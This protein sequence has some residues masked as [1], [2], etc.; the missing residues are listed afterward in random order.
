MKYRRVLK[1]S[2]SPGEITHHHSSETTLVPK[3]HHRAMLEVVW[4]NK[5]NHNWLWLQLASGTFS[6]PRM[7]L[8]LLSSCFLHSHMFQPC[9]SCPCRLKLQHI[10]LSIS[11]GGIQSVLQGWSL[12][13]P[14]D[15]IVHVLRQP[16]LKGQSAYVLNLLLSGSMKPWPTCILR[17]KKLNQS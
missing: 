11:V 10:T 8:V 14:I 3:L 16:K 13:L 1:S 15:F 17:K 7:V 4:F 9:L 2:L 12:F 6:P 5:W